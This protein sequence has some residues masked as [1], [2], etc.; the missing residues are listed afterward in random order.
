[1][2]ERLGVSAEALMPFLIEASGKLKAPVNRQ[3]MAGFFS[4][5][6]PNVRKLGLL[7][8]NNGYLREKWGEAGLLEWEF[9]DDT[10]T[11]Y[12]EYDEVAK[13]REAAAAAAS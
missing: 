12:A 2:W 5:L 7:D 8:S 13:D 4:K 9:A 11:D 1:V 10:S 6:V 3:F